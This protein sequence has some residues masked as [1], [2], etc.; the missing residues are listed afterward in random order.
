MTDRQFLIQSY[1]LLLKSETD[2]K[3]KQKLSAKIE[4]L[5]EEYETVNHF[6]EDYDINDE[7]R[8][9]I[10][11]YLEDKTKTCALDI[12]CNCLKKEKKQF[13][14]RYAY[15]LNRLIEEKEEWTRI[16][17]IRL[18]SDNLNYHGRGYIKE[19]LNDD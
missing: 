15:K 3:Q 14:N 9:I 13:N 5:L 10:N 7:I 17:S 6:A 19:I 11:A 4:N 8:S 1:L 16:S 18:K 2:E 12:W